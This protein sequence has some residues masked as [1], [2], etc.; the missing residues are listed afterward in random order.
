MSKYWRKRID[1]EMTHKQQQDTQIGDELKRL[2]DYHMSQIEKEIQAFYQRYAVNNQISVADAKKLADRMDV[3]AFAEKAKRYVEEK[4]FSPQAN[5]E[6][7][8]YNLKMKVSRLELL[9]YNMDLEMLALANGEY[10]LT[11]R[12]L[13]REFIDEMNFQAGILGEV[14]ASPKSIASMA[15]GIIDTP[16]HGATW[17]ENIWRRQN[18][19]RVIVART[20]ED[21][22]LRGRSALNMIPQLRKEFNVSKAHAKRL[23]V[24]ETARIQTAVQK[25]SYEA[26]GFDEYEFMAEPSACPICARLDGKILKVA[27][28]EPGRNAAPMHPHCHCSTAPAVNKVRLELEETLKSLE[29]NEIELSRLYRNKNKAKR[30]TINIVKQ[31][32]LTKEFRERGGVVWQDD[33]SEDYLKSRGAQAACLDFETIALQKKPTVSEVLEEIFHAEQWVDGR[34][35]DTDISKIKGEIEAQEY[36]LSVSKRYNIPESEIQETKRNLEYW[37]KELRKHEN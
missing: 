21:T 9:Q 8:L 37:K 36:L 25:A 15:Q 12:F 22:L 33:E 18:A 10:K 11:E 19:L 27:D 34:V 1:E 6:L 23:A 5:A 13:N 30:R 4:N 16:Y 32:K 3:Q 35:E 20:A 17:S 2:H 24:T 28:M 7:A 14:V 26:N 31:N 29:T